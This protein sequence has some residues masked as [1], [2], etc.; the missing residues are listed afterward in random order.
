MRKGPAQVH[1]HTAS[2]FQIDRHG[3]GV[4]GMPCVGG[5]EPGFP[6]YIHLTPALFG[7]AHIAAGGGVEVPVIAFLS[8]IVEILPHFVR[9]LDAVVRAFVRHIRHHAP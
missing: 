9:L 4:L 8:A 6:L 2:V 5:A 1:I 3:V 7:D